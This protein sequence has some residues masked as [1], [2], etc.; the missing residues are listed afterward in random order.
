M[1]IA[2]RW[3]EI[4]LEHGSKAYC[5]SI[6]AA[7]KCVS[8]LKGDHKSNGKPKLAGPA[9]ITTP[10]SGESEPCPHGGE[11][12]YDEE[13]CVRCHD[14]KPKGVKASQATIEAVA[15]EAEADLGDLEPDEGGAEAEAHRVAVESFA[16][17][18]KHLVEAHRLM[19][20][21]SQTHPHRYQQSAQDSL[22][23]SYQDLRRWKKEVV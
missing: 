9:K 15:D 13:A 7:L 20:R 16:A 12:E 23:V 2:E 19:S 3:P 1:A 22:D 11:H 6:D 5:M 14:P 18:E 10:T 4:E 17:A 21:L 8:G